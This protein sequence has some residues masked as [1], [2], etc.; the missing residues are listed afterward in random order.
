MKKWQ[1]Y[2][3]ENQI[4][5]FNKN[6]KGET[7]SVDTPPPTISGKMHIGHASSYTHE[8]IIVRYER[9]KNKK[10]IFPFGTDDNGLPTEKFIEKKKTY[11]LKECKEMNSLNFA[12]KH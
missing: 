4:Y 9:M 11:L 8:D 12:I 5:K 7:Y 2:W 6:H 10:I 3:E 1:N